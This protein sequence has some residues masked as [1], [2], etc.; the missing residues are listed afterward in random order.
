LLS[1]PAPCLSALFLIFSCCLAFN[2][3]NASLPALRLANDASLSLLAFSAISF[4]KAGNVG[5]VE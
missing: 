3:S 5:L 4:G 1:N 2:A